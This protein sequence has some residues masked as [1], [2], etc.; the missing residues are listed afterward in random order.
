M[1]FLKRLIRALPLL[2]L[3]PFFM[4]ISFLALLLRSTCFD[5]PA[6]SGSCAGAAAPANY[7]RPPS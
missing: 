6:A 1:A 4:A 3:S 5:A 2:L 7:A